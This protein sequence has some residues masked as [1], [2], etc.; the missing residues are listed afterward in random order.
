MT[1][2]TSEDA[3]E[4]FPVMGALE[5]LSGELACA[6]ITDSQI[7]EI[8]AMHY[9]MALHHTRYERQEYFSINQK[10]HRKILE[11]TGNTILASVYNSLAGR[12]RRVRYLANIDRARWDQAM[13][14]HAQI[15]A[16][17]EARDGVKL[18]G[19]L[20]SHL[21]RTLAAVKATI[22]VG[23]SEKNGF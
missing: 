8:K 14:E 7:A 13:V 21:M 3:E 1:R 15:L 16:A 6:S 23:S 18:A 17:L 12:I 9:Q 11:T 19:L 4:L 2:L 22:E 5:A 10:I 20:K